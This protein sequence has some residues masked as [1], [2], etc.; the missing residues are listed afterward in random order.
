MPF[1]PGNKLAK[2]GRQDKP[3]RDALVMEIKSAGAD[4]A[5]LRKIAAQLIAQAEKGDLGCIKEVADRLDGK[6]AQALEHSGEVSI[7]TVMRAPLPEATT[8][9][10]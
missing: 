3:F 8:D 10:W 6:P 7:P 4:F 9:E 2:G 5:S 1:Q